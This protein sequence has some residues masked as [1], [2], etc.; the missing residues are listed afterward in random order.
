VRIYLWTL[1]GLLWFLAMSDLL[2]C[3][4]PA[5]SGREFPVEQSGPIKLRLTLPAD[6][7]PRA[8]PL[9]SVG[10]A[11]HGDIVFIYY[12][13]GNRVSLGWEQVGQEAL[14]SDPQEVPAGGNCEIVI[15]LGSLMPTEPDFYQRKP[16]LTSLRGA[17]VVQFAGRTVLSARGV[18]TPGATK[19]VVAGANVVGGAMATAYFQGRIEEITTV[20]PGEILA[21]GGT[22]GPAGYPGPVRIQLRFPPGRAGYGEP[23]VVTGA[24]GAGDI[25]YVRY[26]SEHRLRIGFDHWNKGGPV[27]RQI[28]YDPG[29]AHELILSLGSLLPSMGPGGDTFAFLRRRCSILLDGTPVLACESEFYPATPAQVFVGENPIGGSTTGPAFTG[30]IIRVEPVKPE[31]WTAFMPPF[32]DRQ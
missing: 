8:E 18:F 12:Q 28:E 20:E 29:T 27:S 1:T 9:L 17:V 14:L 7:S 31:Q 23:L 3:G 30:Q 25:V 16:E 13:P 11:G 21:G 10:Q 15:S 19:Q 22:E 6:R 24:T 2:V 32:T 4:A 26:V 5:A